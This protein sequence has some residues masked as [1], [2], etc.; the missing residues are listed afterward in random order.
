MFM[1]FIEMHFS[2]VK[3]TFT[4]QQALNFIGNDKY[5]GFRDK[6]EG[7]RFRHVHCYYVCSN[8]HIEHMLCLHGMY[9]YTEFLISR[10]MDKPKRME[11]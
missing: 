7:F 2:E 1:E 5:E 8:V 9:I 6:Y 11:V 4:G 3:I 10:V